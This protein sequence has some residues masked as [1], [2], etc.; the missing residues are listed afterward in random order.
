MQNHQ[1]KQFFHLWLLQSFAWYNRLQM[2]RWSHT[3]S[4]PELKSRL[5]SLNGMAGELSSPSVR[6]QFTTLRE[7]VEQALLLKVALN[8]K[9][10]PASTPADLPVAPG[11]SPSPAYFD[12]VEKTLSHALLHVHL[13][14]IE[15][16]AELRGQS[17]Q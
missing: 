8:Q 5:H 4:I 9:E 6:Q 13:A 1:F 17:L 7:I 10:E 11:H 15:R 2:K 16:Q 14:K 3:A 12:Q